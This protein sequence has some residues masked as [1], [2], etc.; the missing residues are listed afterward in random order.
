MLNAIEPSHRSQPSVSLFGSLSPPQTLLFGFSAGSPNGI[1]TVDDCKTVV[2][3]H[4]I[5]EESKHSLALNCAVAKMT[6]Y[7]KFDSFAD[8]I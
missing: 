8:C 3:V 4:A 1:Y 7:T 6:V 2:K 5:A